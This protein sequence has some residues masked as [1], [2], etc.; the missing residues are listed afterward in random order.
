MNLDDK[1]RAVLAAFVENEKGDPEGAWNSFHHSIAA[2]AGGNFTTADAVCR[3]LRRRKL[4][5]GEGSGKMASYYPTDK[6]RE[7]LA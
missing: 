7:A 3:N 1:E 5:K 2:A 6:G 4:L